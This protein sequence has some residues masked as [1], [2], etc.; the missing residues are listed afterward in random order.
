MFGDHIRYIL[1]VGFDIMLLLL[2]MQLEKLGFI[3]LDKKSDVFATFKK[4]KYLVENE[5]GRRLKCL[6]SDNGGGY[7]NKEFD[8]YYSYHGICRE[9]R[10]LGTQ[11]ENG[12][13]ERMNK[14]IMEHARCMRL[15]AGF[16]L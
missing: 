15:H 7:C 4:W 12:V 6:I 3:P 2:M 5:I 1:L 10:A 11:Q 16:P 13:L 14:T 8:N 9:K